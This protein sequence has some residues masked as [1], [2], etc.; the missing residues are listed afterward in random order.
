MKTLLDVCKFLKAAGT[1]YL[2]TVDG[3]TEAVQALY[4]LYQPVCRRLRDSYSCSAC[5]ADS[6]RRR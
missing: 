5:V 3:D 4:R 2:A 1:Y 6:V